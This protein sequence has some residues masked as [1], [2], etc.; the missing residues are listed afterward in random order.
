MYSKTIHSSIALLLVILFQLPTWLQ[1]EHSFQEHD[2]IYA[3]DNENNNNYLY[4]TNTNDCSFLHQ[5]LN[6][7]FTID[8]SHF[9]FLNNCYYFPIKSKISSNFSLQFIPFA[10]LRAPPVM[11][12]NV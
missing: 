6:F 1:F 8:D 11:F 12:L 2:D 5:Q 7:N 10:Q 4:Q 9:E 3:S